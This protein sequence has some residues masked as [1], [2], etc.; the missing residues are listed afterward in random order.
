MNKT[1]VVAVVVVVVA[2]GIF[3]YIWYQQVSSLANTTAI[4]GSSRATETLTGYYLQRTVQGPEDA[5]GATSH[6]NY[7]CD[8]FVVKSAGPLAR[9]FLSLYAQGNRVN[10]ETAG[11]GLVLAL[12]TAN[13]NA[14][15]LLAAAKEGEPMP[16]SLN[17]MGPIFALQNKSSLGFVGDDNPNSTSKRRYYIHSSNSF[18]FWGDS[19]G[20]KV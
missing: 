6:T 13:L 14:A 4:S 1:L 12:D 10:G 18:F 19:A 17:R 15:Q 7:T 3:G 11:G 8:A 16:A 5:V 2:F 20:I 9:Y